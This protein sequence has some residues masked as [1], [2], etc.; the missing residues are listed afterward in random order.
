M[1][2][3][4]DIL[5]SNIELRGSVIT[6]LGWDCLE[7][8][9]ETRDPVK[10]ID[11][12][13]TEKVSRMV[14]SVPDGEI[15]EELYPILDFLAALSNPYAPQNEA[16]FDFEQDARSMI[17][18]VDVGLGDIYLMNFDVKGTPHY[19]VFPKTQEDY[20]S[21]KDERD[22]EHFVS[23]DMKKERLIHIASRQLVILTGDASTINYTKMGV[24]SKCT[25]PHEVVVDPTDSRT[26]LMAYKSTRV[27]QPKSEAA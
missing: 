15:P 12:F 10:T 16:I 8:Y 2:S 11:H 5:S 17:L 25:V 7:E 21:F 18:H 27:Q 9:Q 14:T 23:V 4:S 6:P 1:P 20:E 13:F 22:A 3:A 19:R 26:L 24:I